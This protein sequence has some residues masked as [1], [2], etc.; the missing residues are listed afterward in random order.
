M[1]QTSEI[2]TTVKLQEV[3]GL[4]SYWRTEVQGIAF[5]DEGETSCRLI[6]ALNN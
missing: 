1:M 5:I 4:H 2:E 6:T 3:A